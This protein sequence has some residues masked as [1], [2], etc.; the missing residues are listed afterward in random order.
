MFAS[1]RALLSS[2]QTRK[3][4]K[5]EEVVNVGADVVFTKISIEVEYLRS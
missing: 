1:T 4:D 5:D 2:A 3:A